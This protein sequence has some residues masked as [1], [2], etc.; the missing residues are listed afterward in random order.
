[1]ATFLE[2]PRFPDDIA[3]W[4]EGGA[5]FKTVV[6][7]STSGR[8]KRNSLW[9]YAMGKWKVNNVSRTVFVPQA[10]NVAQI[11]NFFRA[12]KGQAFGFR[13][14]DWTDYQDE[15]AGIVGQP[16][17]NFSASNFVPVGAGTGGPSYQMYKVYSENPFAD[18]RV[19][20][21]PFNGGGLQVQR[22]GVNVT[23]GSAAGDCSI[24]TT[25]GIVT[26]V[27]DSSAAITGWT[28][29][30]TTQFTVAAV[31]GGWAVGKLLYFTSVT[32][33]TGGVLNNKAVSISAI[34]GTTV[35]VAANTV[36]DT[37]SGGTASMYPQA[38]DALAWTGTFDTPCRFSTDDFYASFD[39]SGLVM[40]DLEIMEIRL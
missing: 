28:A 24:D 25:T 37:L 21:K 34:A 17:S 14:R 29:G 18:Y 39:T 31:P 15:G 38:A 35:T 6:T 5:G 32:G 2:T 3:F 9:Q 19:V 33:D 16:F 40:I 10:Y 26:F 22:N 30:A 36:G 13:F 8:E 1:M 11:R 20:Q 27:A 12:M 7:T 23:Q 4:A